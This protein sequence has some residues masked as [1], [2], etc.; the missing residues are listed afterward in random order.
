MI[1]IHYISNKV[2]FKSVTGQGRSHSNQASHIFSPATD[3]ELSL[4]CFV[5]LQ[6]K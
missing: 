4:S 5:V 6:F 3:I 2:A 1:I